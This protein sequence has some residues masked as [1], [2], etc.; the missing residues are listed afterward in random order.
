MLYESI[1]ILL[2]SISQKSMMFNF[3]VVDIT[4]RS[5][6]VIFCIQIP[7][8]IVNY[9][10]HFNSYNFCFDLISSYF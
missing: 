5:G 1:D 4:I 7:R 6:F 2:V 9:A 3:S 10:K 8:H